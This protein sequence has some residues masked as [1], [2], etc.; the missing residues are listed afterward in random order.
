MKRWTLL[1]CLLLPLAG[2]AQ[3]NTDL[4]DTGFHSSTAIGQLE[5]MS[6]QS[7]SRPSYSSGS[8]STSSGSSY[9]NSG[10]TGAEAI[11]NAKSKF[12][13]PSPR[14]PKYRPPR[15][16]KAQKAYA[17]KLR[18]WNARSRKTREKAQ[19]YART[20]H[21][22]LKDIKPLAENPSGTAIPR[23]VIRNNIP[24][25]ITLD[26]PV[27][28]DTVWTK[29][30]DGTLEGKVQE[31]KYFAFGAIPGEEGWFNEFRFTNP[32]SKEISI[33]VEYEVKYGK[34]GATRQE[35][36]I[37]HMPPAR[38]NEPSIYNNSLGVYTD[39]SIRY[40]VLNV[41]RL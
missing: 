4:F 21:F 9:S 32:T 29:L 17:R 37:V 27:Y 6:G 38:I 5:E 40:R 8:Y 1:V 26:Y 11:R 7:I 30:P 28:R 22:K 31:S 15:P 33:R 14:T 18:K 10:T 36:K 3:V 24:R 2:W 41:T 19:R 13:K 34:D 20:S 16:T 39:N 12:K 23:M 25:H 35:H